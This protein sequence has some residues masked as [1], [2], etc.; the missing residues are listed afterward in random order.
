MEGKELDIDSKQFV[1]QSERLLDENCSKTGDVQ[2][3][4]SKTSNIQTAWN[5]LNLTQGIGALGIP[6]A[7]SIG[8][9]VTIPYCLLIGYITNYTSMLIVDTLYEDNMDELRVNR[10]KVRL[11]F[12]ALGGDTWQ[13]YG[14]VITSTIQIIHLFGA[15]ILYLILLHT[16]IDLL[17]RDYFQSQTLCILVSGVLLTPTAVVNNMKQLSWLNLTSVCLVDT[18]FIIFIVI[19]VMNYKM[20]SFDLLIFDF[21]GFSIA[22]CIILFSFVAH[23]YL[24]KIENSMKHQENYNLVSTLSFTTATVI[25]I[26]FGTVVILHYGDDIKQTISHNVED[27]TIKLCVT[28]LLGLVGYFSFA[29]PST[30]ILKI[31]I[32][33]EI[34]IIKKL[35]PLSSSK[36]GNMNWEE[37][38]LNVTLR[39][40]LI[41]LIT[42]ITIIVP[43]FSVLM[44][45]IGSVTAVLLTLILPV[46]FNKVLKEKRW[47]FRF[48]AIIIFG[49]LSGAIG[50]T[51]SL[52]KLIRIMEVDK[53]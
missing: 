20:W 33:S 34:N 31:L 5:I 27:P 6:Y 52:W 7:I 53:Y 17:Y 25:K 28:C 41:A 16:F 36:A 40:T 48:V 26:L 1:D 51:N 32:N 19:S 4:L 10:K 35:F 30:I 9:L 23:P 46:Y 24:P 11:E 50:L 45:V 3:D 42:C 43:V 18:V 44:A 2:L 38:F 22:N 49:V 15:S 29:M 12:G 8:G 13:K 14:S 47:T 21:Q 39:L 37:K